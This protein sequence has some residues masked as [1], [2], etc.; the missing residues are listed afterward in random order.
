MFTVRTMDASSL[1]VGEWE[2][3]P[4]LSL[5]ASGTPP[6]AGEYVIHRQ[7]DGTILLRA[8]WRAS[9]AADWQEVTFGGLP[10]GSPHPLP[11]TADATDQT[12][13]RFT[14]THVDAW[15]LD[16]A[17]VCG[18]RPVATARRVASRD[19]ALLA[20]VQEVIRPSGD[21]SRNFQVYRRRAAEPRTP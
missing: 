6:V 20:V 21:C 2:L 1:Y 18:E 15:T 17:A 8:R 13:D 16:S 11:V 12:P 9:A 3:I 5:Y 7:P 14:L 10:D 19:G 4:E